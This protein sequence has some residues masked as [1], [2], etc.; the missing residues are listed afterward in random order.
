MSAS[1]AQE[2]LASRAAQDALVRWV[3]LFGR[4]SRLPWLLGLHVDLVETAFHL[5]DERITALKLDWWAQALCVVDAVNRHP[6]LSMLQPDRVTAHSLSHA[7]L[8]LEH[9]QTPGSHQEL[10][11]Q[12]MALAA[13]CAAWVADAADPAALA[14]HGL[15]WRLRLPLPA[16][17]NA[18]LCPL[19]LRARHQ[20]PTP[21]PPAEWPAPLRSDWVSAIGGHYVESRRPP[22]AAAGRVLDAL[23]SREFGRAKAKP[24][25]WQVARAGGGLGGVWTAWRA[26][27]GA[28]S[29]G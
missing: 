8:A 5:S 20:L 7:L 24:A 2:Q 9:Q 29:S 6:W 28:P 3:Q 22:A 11:Q 18:G 4:G 16:P 26:A 12:A 25:T 13:P 15:L 10:W 1:A 17:H 14:A 23:L 27:L 21:R 19:D